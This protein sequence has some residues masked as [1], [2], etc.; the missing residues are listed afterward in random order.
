MP[1]GQLWRFHAPVCVR[2]TCVG[3]QEYQ[4]SAIK[5]TKQCQR[6]QLDTMS[7]PSTNAGSKYGWPGIQKVYLPIPR[8]CG[9]NK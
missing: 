6:Q 4:Y 2:E 1:T 5:T 3:G 7:S 9:I 8:N